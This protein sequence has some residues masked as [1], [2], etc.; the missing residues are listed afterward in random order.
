MNFDRGQRSRSRSQ[1]NVQLW[2]EMYRN[3]YN[4]VLYWRTRRGGLS[5]CKCRRYTPGHRTSC[6]D[7]TAD[8]QN[9]FWGC[10]SCIHA[11][12]WFQRPSWKVVRD[13]RSWVVISWMRRQVLNIR[14]R[15]QKQF[16]PY[17]RFTCSLKISLI[18]ISISVCHLVDAL[19]N[20]FGCKY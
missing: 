5:N 16:P 8:W 20:M 9:A 17:N 4:T 14:R 15:V 12:M 3:W 11:L 13:A 6:R 2:H 18:S 1:G 10:V 19:Q 7:L